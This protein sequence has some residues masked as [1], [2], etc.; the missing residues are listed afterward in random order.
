MVRLTQEEI[1]HLRKDLDV[2]DESSVPSSY[3]WSRRKYA[4]MHIHS[5]S[6]SK[7]REQIRASYPEYVLAFDVLFEVEAGAGVALH[8]DYESL[9]PFEYDRTRSVVES[10]FRSIHFNLTEE[11]GSL[12]TLPWPFLSLLHHWVI[13]HFGLYSGVHRVC[14]WFARPLVAAFGV[15]HPNEAGVGNGFDNL[16]LHMVTPGKEP[17]V[18]YVVRLVKRG[19]GVRTSPSLLARS[20][21]PAS[22]ALHCAI[23]RHVREVTDVDRVPWQ[24]LREEGEREQREAVRRGA[25]EEEARPHS[26][27]APC[28][29]P[30]LQRE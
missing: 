29:S 4:P 27:F 12:V 6:L 30:L 2:V 1:S 19:A 13:S 3:A 5:P 20:H 26:P 28:A 23:A 22:R 14:N 9:G 16:L 8:C 24:R 25:S 17:R 10:H 7:V 21:A 18:S 11:G 15:V